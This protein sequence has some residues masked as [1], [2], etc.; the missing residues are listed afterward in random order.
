LV[1]FTNFELN[2]MKIL[3]TAFMILA[4][5][6]AQAATLDESTVPGGNFS[7]NVALPTVVGPSI[8]RVTGTGNAGQF[9]LFMFTG[10]AAGAQTLRFDFAAP[11]GIADS[12]SAGG[13]LRYSMSPFAGT[14]W[15]GGFDFANPAVYSTAPTV[16]ETL[17]L[18]PSFAGSLYLA[19]NFTFG[20]NMNYMIMLPPTPIPATVPVPAAGLLLLSVLGG[21]GLCARRSRA[22]QNI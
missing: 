7:S 9:D 11:S 15:N 20:S 14:A 5:T 13:T 2:T 6:T 16:T 21:L 18:G 10:L 12:Y 22:A 4:T 19:M 3:L 8:S 1:E 17:T